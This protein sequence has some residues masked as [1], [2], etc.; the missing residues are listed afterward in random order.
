MDAHDVRVRI[1]PLLAIV[2]DKI[3]RRTGLDPDAIP[4]GLVKDVE[5]YGAACVQLVADSVHDRPTKPDHLADGF[6]DEPT[7][8]RRL[9]TRRRGR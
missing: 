9:P 2:L 3:A 5:D 6:D 1:R 8:V 7:I 4:H